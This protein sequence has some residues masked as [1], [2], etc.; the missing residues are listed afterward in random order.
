MFEMTNISQTRRRLYNIWCIP[1][2]N[3][4]SS[5]VCSVSDTSVA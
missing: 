3:L 5:N 4:K 1:S 2:T